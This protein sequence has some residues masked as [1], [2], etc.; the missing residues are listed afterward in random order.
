[1]FFLFFCICLIS[2]NEV[3]AQRWNTN[4]VENK[5]SALPSDTSKSSKLN[6]QSYNDSDGYPISILNLGTGFGTTYGGFGFKTV[7]GRKNSGLLVGLGS[8]FGLG[9]GYSIGGQISLKW[10]YVSASYGTYLGGTRFQSGNFSEVNV[11]VGVHL[12]TGAMVNL[13]KPKRCFL[14]FG[15][16]LSLG[17]TIK[18]YTISFY[19]TTSS[20]IPVTSLAVNIGFGVRIGTIK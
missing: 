18:T 1:M 15:I 14:D 17:G 20:S 6:S 19:S 3:F 16:G 7:I 4:T 13:G 5:K 2:K 10:W 12:M 8:N 9:L 11:P